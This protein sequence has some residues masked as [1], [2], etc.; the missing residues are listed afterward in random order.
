MYGLD[1]ADVHNK[2]T[3]LYESFDERHLSCDLRKRCLYMY[4][5]YRALVG[6]RFRLSHIFFSLKHIYFKLEIIVKYTKYIYIYWE[7]ISATICYFSTTCV[8][9]SG[10]IESAVLCSAMLQLSERAD[11]SHVFVASR[12]TGDKNIAVNLTIGQWDN[13]G[14]APRKMLINVAQVNEPLTESCK[15]KTR[16]Y[17]KRPNI[18]ET[19]IKSKRSFLFYLI[20]FCSEFDIIRF[21]FLKFFL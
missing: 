2:I 16:A 9:G 11:Q 21:S 3:N 15:T 8:W 12:S 10:V 14:L 18:R 4:L 19:A 1:E 7:F 20:M 17:L 5:V 13:C 6:L